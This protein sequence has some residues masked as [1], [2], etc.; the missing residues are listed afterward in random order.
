MKKQNESLVRV[1]FR[2]TKVNFL[3]LKRKWGFYEESK[4]K[5]VWSSA[6]YLSGGRAGAR[7]Y[8]GLGGG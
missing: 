1:L 3:N 6:N 2:E 5:R 8:E 7:V 4:T